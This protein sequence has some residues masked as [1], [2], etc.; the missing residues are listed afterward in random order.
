[1][2]FFS[3]LALARAGW[4]DLWGKSGRKRQDE[5]WAGAGIL[6]ERGAGLGAREGQEHGDDPWVPAQC[7][8]AFSNN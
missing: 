3:K 2:F 4:M 7:E 5:A 1:M 8:E 6:G